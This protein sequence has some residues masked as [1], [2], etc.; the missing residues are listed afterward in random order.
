MNGTTLNDK[1]QDRVDPII[2]IPNLSVP[3]PKSRLPKLGGAKAA[4]IVILYSVVVVWG[5]A[6]VF[7]IALLLAAAL[8]NLFYSFFQVENDL[9]PPIELVLHWLGLGRDTLSQLDYVIHLLAGATRLAVVLGITSFVC[10]RVHNSSL[11]S[12][13]LFWPARPGLSIA[14]C[15][16]VGLVIAPLNFLPVAL[17]SMSSKDHPDLTAYLGTLGFVSLLSLMVVLLEEIAFRGYV[18]QIL[19]QSWGGGVALILSSMVFALVHFAAGPFN[20]N[21]MVGLFALGLMFGYVFLQT[22]NLWCSIAIHLG[23]NQGGAIVDTSIKRLFVDGPELLSE[24][25]GSWEATIFQVILV[26]AC[27][28]I[29]WAWVKRTSRADA[30]HG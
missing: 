16:C 20:V 17:Q 24:Y 4:L 10:R 5:G 13:G 29:V 26:S 25:F 7:I 9:M 18:L 11:F 15:F 12:L 27:A 30:V 1:G 21:K 3:G 8:L 22:R 6:V 28:V 19:E 14:F 2:E 23:W